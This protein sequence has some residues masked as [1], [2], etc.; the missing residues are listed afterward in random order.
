MLRGVLGGPAVGD[1][2]ERVPLGAEVPGRVRIGHRVIVPSPG[3]LTHAVP[4]VVECPERSVAAVG[5]QG[6]LTVV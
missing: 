4:F 1:D 3:T 5:A 6:P 2:G